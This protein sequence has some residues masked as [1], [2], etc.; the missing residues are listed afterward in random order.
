MVSRQ[1]SNRSSPYH[2]SCS[3]PYPFQCTKYSV[4][5]LPLPYRHC[6]LASTLSTSYS[7]HSPSSSITGS[8]FEGQGLLYGSLAGSGQGSRWATE[9]TGCI[10]I[11]RGNSNL[12]ASDPTFLMILKGPVCWFESFRFPIPGKL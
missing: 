2:S 3:G 10:R 4:M 9:M 12:Y 7:F 1:P 11:V 6:L 5:L 8:G